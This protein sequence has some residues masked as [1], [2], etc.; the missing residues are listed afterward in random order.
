M[1]S[2]RGQTNW[3]KRCHMG[4]DNNTGVSPDQKVN[5]ADELTFSLYKHWLTLELHKWPYPE[6]LD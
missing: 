1:T 3:Q 2:F 5:K 4:Q 6:T